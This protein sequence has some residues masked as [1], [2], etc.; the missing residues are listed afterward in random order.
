MTVRQSFRIAVMWLVVTIVVLLPMAPWY[1]ADR[2]EAESAEM[3]C[4]A[5]QV[6]GESIELAYDDGVSTGF[7]DTGCDP[8]SNYQGV[9]FSLAAGVKSAAITTVRFYCKPAIRGAGQVQVY[10]KGADRVTDLVPMISY[11]AMATGWHT[12][13]LS[14][15]VAKG[16]FYVFVRRLKE[17]TALGHDY[18]GDHGRSWVA[19]D[20]SI[21]E[22]WSVV[23]NGGRG[24]IMI[25]ATIA[26]E[27]HVG[28]GQDYPTIQAAVDAA[29]PG[30]NIIVHDGTYNENVTVSKPLAIRSLQ[31]PTKTIVRTASAERNTF[32]ITSPNV[33]LSGFTIEHITDFGSAGVSLESDGC[34]LVSGNVIMD[35]TYGIYVSENSTKNI[36]LENDCRLNT[37]GIYV[38]GSQNYISGNKL[39]GNTA[40]IGSA[41]LVSDGASG[42]FLRFNSITVDAATD[43]LVAGDSHVYNQ[44]SAEE[45]SATYNWWG[46]A[47]GPSS[48]GGE[49]SAV[50]G[51]ALVDPWLNVAPLRVQTEST[52]AGAYTINSKAE[53]SVEVAKEGS[54][55]PVVSVASFAENPV[56]SV[57]SLTG[58]TVGRFPAKP[59]GK[60]I[61]ALFSSTDG[62]EQAE[63]RVFYTADEVAGVKEGSL[64]LYWWNG[65]KWSVCSKSRVDK[66]FDFVWTLVDLKSKPGLTDLNGT[67][68]AVGIPKGGGVDWWLIPLIFVIVVILLIAFRLFWVLVV[69]SE[70]AV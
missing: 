12:V 30:L 26:Q 1:G 59:I 38:D 25:R 56:V 24:D 40:P 46:S 36:L 35:N 14:R 66:G 37:N 41:V 21:A 55:M 29:S 48:A 20:P 45:L 70:R 44:N 27:I 6:G 18:W 68:F 2:V 10:I 65:E 16:D 8:C 13:S 67:Y 60:W 52:N 34:C 39:H 57:D 43:P 23:N 42:N 7:V 64:R 32:T 33:K 51:M 53:T 54:G 3:W 9:R 5:G 11:T 22:I 17:G 28:K 19:E 50:G 69:K 31:G 61:D 49:V 47:S 15:A 58:K 62:V 63:I 4:G